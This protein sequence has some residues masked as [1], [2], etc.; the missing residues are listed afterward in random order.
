MTF[1]YNS[2]WL[3]LGL[4]SL[5]AALTIQAQRPSTIPGPEQGRQ[6]MKSMEKIVDQERVQSTAPRRADWEKVQADASRLLTL[7]QRI[8]DQVQGGHEKLPAPVA[9]ELNEIQK[10]TKRLR[11]ELLL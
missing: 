1:V 6:T 3:L 11:D 5:A 8:H 10:L 7:A 2:R 9:G 4:F